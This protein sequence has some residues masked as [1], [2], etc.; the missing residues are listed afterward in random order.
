MMEPSAT[1][2]SGSFSCTGVRSDD[3]KVIV[4]AMGSFAT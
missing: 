2:I 1:N 3:G 4:D